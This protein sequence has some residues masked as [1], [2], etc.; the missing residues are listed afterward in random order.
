VPAQSL[1]TDA[2]MLLR[3]PAADAFH[4][5]SAFSALHGPLHLLQRIPRKSA[6]TT[7]ALDLFDEVALVLESP[8][9]GRTWFV[10]E[11]R[12]L[13]RHEGLGRSYD[14]LRFCSAFAALLARN[15][16]HEDSRP[17][18]AALIRQALAAFA[19]G[20]RPDL[21]YF[22]SLYRF[23]RDEG[24]P[25]KQHWFE[26]LPATDRTAVAGVLNQPIASQAIPP[27]EAARLL[28]RL[29]DY[30]RGH[31]EVLLD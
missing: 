11:A 28:L 7:P 13:V 12:V 31:T 26:S 2:F 1:Q 18:V 10:L 8:N 17:A 30:L 19:T 21:V 25:V 27:G 4:G 20:P 16:V 3:R 22:K 14:T 5:W 15:P 9:Q 24:Y 29:E 6:A 23:A